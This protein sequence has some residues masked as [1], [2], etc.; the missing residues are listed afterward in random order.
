MEK[1]YEN[2]AEIQD[3]KKKDDDKEV[4]TQENIGI[5]QL[6]ILKDTDHENKN[7][8]NQETKLSISK[9]SKNITSASD[10]IKR[11]IFK[12]K[13]NES[14]EK[15]FDLNPKVDNDQFFISNSNIQNDD[16]TMP[17]VCMKILDLDTLSKPWIPIL[18]IVHQDNI[19]ACEIS[20]ELSLYAP[21]I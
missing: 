13:S 1:V 7:L 8:K 20:S 3:L 19:N 21:L 4:D 5:P 9:I 2:T 10:A 15:D 11:F 6:I 16:E 18:L 12:G 17:I 14:N